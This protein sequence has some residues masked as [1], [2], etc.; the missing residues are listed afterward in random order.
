LTAGVY[1]AGFVTTV[2]DQTHTNNNYAHSYINT[3][4]TN[5]SDYQTFAVM[6]GSQWTTQLTNT[7]VITLSASGRI[8]GTV[9]SS[10][11]LDAVSGFLSTTR[12][13]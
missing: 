10:V 1:L 2:T 3:N 8:Y 11:A 6:G 5:H 4:A 7:G 9:W 13:A 12:I